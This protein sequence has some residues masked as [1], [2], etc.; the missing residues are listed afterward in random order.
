[1]I[2]PMCFDCQYFTKRDMPVPLTI[3]VPRIQGQSVE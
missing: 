2:T 3:F 1:M